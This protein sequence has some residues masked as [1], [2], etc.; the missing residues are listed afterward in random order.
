MGRLKKQKQ[1]REA[2]LEHSKLECLQGYSVSI[3]Y[4]RQLIV[5]HL[6]SSEFIAMKTFMDF[7]LS[8]LGLI[9]LEGSDKLTT[10][11]VP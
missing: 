2:F 7:S 8:Q 11:T 4:I 6:T 3:S 1:T 10:G 5:V 9:L